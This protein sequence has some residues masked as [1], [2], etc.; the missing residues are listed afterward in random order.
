MKRLLKLAGL[1]SAGLATTQVQA[2]TISIGRMDVHDIKS[3]YFQINDDQKVEIEFLAPKKH[4]DDNNDLVWIIDLNSRETVWRSRNADVLE[5]SSNKKLKVFGDK[6]ALDKGRYALYFSTHNFRHN[7]SQG[8]ELFLYGLSSLWRDSKS[9]NRDDIE[10]LYVDL[11]GK[12]IEAVS[13]DNTFSPFGDSKKEV[14]SLRKM[15]KN[16]H[17][18]FGLKVEQDTQLSIYALGEI[19]GND[20]ADFAWLKNVDSGKIVWEMDKDTT[21]A[22]GGAK[23]NRMFKGKVPVHKGNYVLS[24]SSDGS[25]HYNDWNSRPPYDPQA[26]GV[27]VYADKTAKIALFDPKEQRRANQILAIDGVGDDANITKHFKLSK[28]ATL[29]IH[30]LGERASSK[31]MADYGWIVDNKSNLTVWEM[32]AKQTEH[33]GGSSKNRSIDEEITL[34]SGSYSVHYQS[35]GSHS[36]DDGWNASRPYDEEQWG[37]S[38]YASSDNFDKSTIK[39]VDNPH[40][41]ALAQLTQIGDNANETTTFELNADQKVRIYA[42]GEGDD[43]DMADYGYIKEAETGKRV[44]YMFNDETKHAG[45]ANKNRMISEVITLKKGRYKMYFKSDG[46]HSYDD[47]NANPPTDER[48]YGITVFDASK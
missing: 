40:G 38:L 32:K 43:D 6:I 10:E 17:E 41:I 8:L 21:Q 23:K 27:S 39:I 20:E 15:R 26:W 36:Y 35:D 28:E 30:A 2:D 5:S 18:R 19:V 44:W 22:A 45:G 9:I 34:P 14:I 4:Q 25:H 29:R 12:D 1:I 33:A 48:N 13:R 16:S 42:I 24:Y 47:W 46:S 31:R 7:N 37:I 11:R 3:S